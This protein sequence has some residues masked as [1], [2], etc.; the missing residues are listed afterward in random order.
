MHDMYASRFANTMSSKR[1]VR[2]PN[3]DLASLESSGLLSAYTANAGA[4]TKSD[5]DKSFLTKRNKN[6]KRREQQQK[7]AAED[8]TESKRK[9]ESEMSKGAE[10][11]DDDDAEV[12][13]W[14]DNWDDAEV[15]EED[16]PPPGTCT[17]LLQSLLVLTKKFA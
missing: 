17:T 16:A 14:E 10:G 2:N 1:R 6:Q 13:N 12:D 7:Q 5:A 3:A 11:D 15:S 9:S 8:E 4:G